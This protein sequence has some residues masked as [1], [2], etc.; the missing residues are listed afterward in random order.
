MYYKISEETLTAIAD[1]IREKG[2][3]D[4]LMFP[5]EMPE[6]IRA[7]LEAGT[8]VAGGDLAAVLSGEGGDIITIPDITILREYA[9]YK[10][11]FKQV[12]MPATVNTIS[13]HAFSSMSSLEDLEI[14]ESVKSCSTDAFLGCSALK[15]L[16]WNPISISSMGTS[17]YAA[18][19]EC[20]NLVDVIFGDKVKIIPSFLLW[21]SEAKGI[22]SIRI[23]NCVTTIGEGAFAGTGI[24]NVTISE[25]VAN[26]GRR[27]FLNCTALKGVHWKA[28]SVADGLTYD[29]FF[30]NCTG[31]TTF[32]IANGVTRVPAYLLWNTTCPG[33]KEL[34][35]PE[36]VTYIGA[37]AFAGIGIES[38]TIPK[39]VTNVGA[40]VFVN[41]ASLKTVYWNPEAISSVGSFYDPI[42]SNCPALSQLVFDEA[43]T[44]V[45]EYIARGCKGLTSVTI[46]ANVTT[47]GGNAFADCS[48]LETLI[49]DADRV[50]TLSN[51]NALNNTA[52]AAGTG[53]IYVKDE[54]LDEYKS[55]T[56]W[57]TYAAQIKAKSEL[58]ETA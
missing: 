34:N 6:N 46:P 12:L 37:G 9:L 2:G 24:E 30:Q 8:T 58:E 19:R 1:A 40:R 29:T 13:A 43:V 21:G 45:P 25:T 28:I 36:T 49:L 44:I 48:S 20:H 32:V 35:I 33:I 10:T 51:S 55:A 11:S 52:I 39:S 53:Y 47:I 42:F 22:K 14:S 50:V 41:C 54:Y 17:S 3:Y 38:I 5:G 56:N 7:A 16:R 15:T 23:P 26:V 57:V 4:N 27:A 18:F 31:I